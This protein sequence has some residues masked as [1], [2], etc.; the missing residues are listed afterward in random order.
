VS[1]DAR[2]VFRRIYLCMDNFTF[3]AWRFKVI[4]SCACLLR[5]LSLCKFGDDENYWKTLWSGETR[6]VAHHSGNCGDPLEALPRNGHSGEPSTL[7]Y[8]YDENLNG[9]ICSHFED[10]CTLSEQDLFAQFSLR[11]ISDAH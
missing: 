4:S 9:Y 10:P 3:L 8:T 2:T 6:S 5:L 1:E 7:S 11:E